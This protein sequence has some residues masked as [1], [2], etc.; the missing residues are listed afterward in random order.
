MRKAHEKMLNI[1]SYWFLFSCIVVPDSLRPHRLHHTS[2][3]CLP[4]SPRICSNSCTLSWWC[5]LTSSAIPFSFCLQSSPASGFL[6]AALMVK[7][8]PAMWEAWVQCLD[9]RD[10]LKKEMETH[11]STLAWRIRWTRG[12]GSATVYLQRAGHDWVTNNFTFTF[13]STRVFSNESDLC[14]R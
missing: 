3:F 14:I 13:A 4:L 12:D 1:S 2:L 6:V 5:Y 8:L 7:N 9:W 11:S 10:Y